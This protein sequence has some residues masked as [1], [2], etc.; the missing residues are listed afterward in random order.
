M[1]IL[2]PFILVVLAIMC[3]SC[4]QQHV[5]K[6][7]NLAQLV[8]PFIG[9]DF[10]GNTYPGAQVPF[11]MVQLSPDNGLPG[12]DRISGYFYPDST[13]AGFS[14]T[15]L[16]GTGAG[17][18][19]DI[20]FM[21][22]RFPEK[23]ADKPLGVHSRFS[24]DNEEAHAGYYKVYLEDYNIDVELT[25]GLRSGV[26]RYT[27]K[28]GGASAIRLN[29]SKSMNWDKTLDAAIQV[30]DKQSLSGV[31]HSD[32]WARSQ[33]LFFATT[34]SAPW[35]RIEIDTVQLEKGQVA[36]NAIL[37]YDTLAAGTQIEVYT[38]LS[39]VN[40]DNAFDNLQADV[41]RAGNQSF[42][43]F[44]AYAEAQWNDELKKIQIDTEDANQKAT[45][46]TALYHT[47]LAPVV[48]DDE[49]GSYRG[50]D[51]KVYKLTDT[52]K[53]HYSRFSLWDTYRAAHPLYTFLFPERVGDMVQSFIDFQ[54]QHGRI[55][56][57]NMQGS[58]TDMMIGYHSAPVIADAILKGIGGFDYEAALEACVATANDDDYRGLGLYKKYGYLPWSME[59]ESLSKTLEYAYD[60]ATIARIAKA[61]GKEDLGKEFERRAKFYKNLFNAE[62]K[63]MQPKDKVGKFKTPFDPREYTTDI[64]ESNG[65]QYLWNVQ[66]DIDGLVDLMGGAEAFEKKLDEFF[67]ASVESHEELPLFSTGMI[68]QYAHGNEPSHHVAYLYNKTANP[69]KGRKL[70]RQVMNEFYTN[71]PEG[72]CGNEDCGQ[73]SAW[74]VFSAMGFYPVDPAG[75]IYE[76]GIPL[77][78]ELTLKLPNGKQ[79]VVKAV[80]DLSS[81]AIEKIQLNGITLEGTT[82]THEQILAGGQLDFFLKSQL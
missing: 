44:L 12:W 61:L 39:A 58:E 30:V 49:D 45:F 72:L 63:F 47:M 59:H 21:P 46:Y 79:F 10:V 76:L 37:Y 52:N 23:V 32:G 74:Y 28:S 73:M 40:S 7:T 68:G 29:L 17:D 42:D 51:K 19:Y 48:Y 2:K 18:L 56:V 71:T 20:S 81:T 24:H 38:A 33:T 9:T 1:R 80:G 70:I 41:K 82:I 5:R 26:Q 31:R 4:G 65:W 50:P 27:F 64:T 3:Y 16:S 43:A 60:D 69:D 53:H 34:V 25:A 62:T 67:G 55:P 54:H 15:H 75:G 13:I 77:C 36:M 57:W 78:R 8:N 35:D 11:G 66:Q 22:V 6:E 14:H